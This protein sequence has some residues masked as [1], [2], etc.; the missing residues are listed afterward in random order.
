M[1]RVTTQQKTHHT[2][3]GVCYNSYTHTSDLG[4]PITSKDSA[5]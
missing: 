1:Y 5:Q 2:V 4:Y 3:F